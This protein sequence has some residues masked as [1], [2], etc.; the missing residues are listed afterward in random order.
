MSKKTRRIE[1]QIETHEVS[2]IRMRGRQFRAFC[3]CCQAMAA[4]LT[5]DQVA[6]LLKMSPDKALG[7]VNEGKL[8][9][10]QADRGLALVCGNSLDNKNKAM[11]LKA[12]PNKL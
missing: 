11:V 3:E 10:V 2:V 1:I 12:S 6:V 9:L 7:L 8:H 5:P 4:A